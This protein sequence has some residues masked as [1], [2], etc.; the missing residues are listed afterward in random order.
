ML[1]RTLKTKAKKCGGMKELYYFNKA[2]LLKKLASTKGL[3]DAKAESEDQKLIS[4]KLRDQD[5]SWRI[6]K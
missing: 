3:R 4:A 2:T 5:L 1:L 6:N